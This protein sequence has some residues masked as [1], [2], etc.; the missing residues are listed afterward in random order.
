VDLVLASTSPY[1]R[2]LL[3]RL[4]LP[5]RAVAPVYEECRPDACVD[6]RRL[7]VQ[8]ALGKAVSLLSQARDC[9]V[10]GSD[11]VIC[12][13]G[14]ILTKPGTEARAVAQ[15]LQLAGREHELLTAVAVVR[16]PAAEPSATDDAQGESALVVNRARV[17]ALT[18]AEA[19]AYVRIEQP[20]DCAGAYKSESL[21]I[22][23]FEYIRGDD[24]TAVIGLPL[25]ALTRLLRRFG[26]DPLSDLPTDAG[27]PA[28]GGIGPARPAPS[29]E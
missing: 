18:H 28:P 9:L 6:P 2:E 16:S 14:A 1:R 13:E 21:G 17:R 23:L 4:G 12:C 24:P 15:L 29:E 25:I 5:F 7:V 22:A 27:A 26:V 19:G 10:I 11:Q 3:A 20:L 8:N